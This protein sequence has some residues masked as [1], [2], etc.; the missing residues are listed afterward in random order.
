MS[1]VGGNSDWCGPGGPCRPRG[2]PSSE[3]EPR[4]RRTGRWMDELRC[5]R[6]GAGAS[7]TKGAMS[8]FGGPVDRSRRRRGPLLAVVG[9][10][11]GAVIGVASGW[12]WRTP[13]PAGRWPHPDAHAGWRRP[14]PRQGASSQHPERLALG[15]E[16]LA[17]IPRA[18][19][20]PRQTDPTAS[21]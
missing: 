20:P 13:E 8:N 3:A 5:A 16:P 12:R 9:A 11:L 19:T 1:L 18:S 2:C 17:T 6:L 15:A 7:A 10:L 14:R 21:L 4:S